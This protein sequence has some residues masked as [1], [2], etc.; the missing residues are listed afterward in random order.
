MSSHMD[1]SNFKT[2]CSTFPME[3]TQFN[4]SNNSFIAMILLCATACLFC[5]NILRITYRSNLVF[6]ENKE[7]LFLYDL[8]KKIEG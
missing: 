5:K 4:W 7:F 1:F 6:A 2:M 8:V 3:N